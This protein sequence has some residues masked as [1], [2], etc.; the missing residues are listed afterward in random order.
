MNAAQPLVENTENYQKIDTN[1]VHSVAQQPISTF[2]IDVDT[3]SY[4]NVRRFLPQE[5]SFL[6][7]MPCVLRKWSI[8]LTMIIRSPRESSIHFQFQDGNVRLTL[9]TKCQNY[10]ELGLGLK[11]CG[12]TITPSKFG[13]SY[14][15]FGKYGC[16]E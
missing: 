1:P 8:I 5:V 14:R 10:S 12:S 4:T 13:F 2:S 16:R 9:A 7:S 15:C 6:Q 3:G 11:I